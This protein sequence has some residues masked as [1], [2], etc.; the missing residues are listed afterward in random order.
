M[1]GSQLRKGLIDEKPFRTA[2]VYRIYFQIYGAATTA[3]SATIAWAY[4][5][6]QGHGGKD[7]HAV[8]VNPC[9]R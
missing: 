1:A 4:Q 6:G 8:L 2:K 9:R 5:L 3:I 7:F